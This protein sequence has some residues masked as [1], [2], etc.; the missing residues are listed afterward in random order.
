MDLI[1]TGISKSKQRIFFKWSLF[2]HPDTHSL[3]RQIMLCTPLTPLSVFPFTFLNIKK[4]IKWNGTPIWPR[5]IARVGN[6]NPKL[7]GCNGQSIIIPSKCLPH[8]MSHEVH[9]WYMI[10][11]SEILSKCGPFLPDFGKLKTEFL[12]L[13]HI[14]STSYY[15][16]P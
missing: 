6:L 11:N 12:I 14:Q 1:L 3:Q 2:L 4:I 16:N 7:P 5:S 15:K 9:P 10:I 13:L 8:I